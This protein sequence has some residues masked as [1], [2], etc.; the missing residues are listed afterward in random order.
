MNT[1]LIGQATISTENGNRQADPP[2]GAFAT[3]PQLRS[4]ECR[5]TKA[6]PRRKR[7][8]DRHPTPTMATLTRRNNAPEHETNRRP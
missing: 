5:H 6:A 1:P 3:F 8:V 7:L 2:R 4:D